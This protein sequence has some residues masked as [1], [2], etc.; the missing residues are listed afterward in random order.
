MIVWLCE[1][2]DLH[3]LHLTGQ[4]RANKEVRGGHTH[5]NAQAGAAQ[6]PDLVMK[7]FCVPGT[8]VRSQRHLVLPKQEW[9]FFL[10]RV[11]HAAGKL[12]FR[13]CCAFL[14]GT[15]RRQYADLSLGLKLRA[16]ASAGRLRRPFGSPVAWL[17]GPLAPLV[18]VEAGL[19]AVPPISAVKIFLCLSVALVPLTDPPRE[20]SKRQNLWYDVP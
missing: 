16:V 11:L 17:Q 6:K 9:N 13:I 1:L 15:R 20:R 8:L 4:T 14:S 5:L 19:S 3:V 18:V 7:C 2:V 12:L 10:L